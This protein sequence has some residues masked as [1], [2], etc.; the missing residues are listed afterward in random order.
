MRQWHINPKFLCRKHLL[1]EHVE[2]HMFIGALK[3]GKNL[4]GYIEKGLVE[5]NTLK[6]RHEEIV[7]ELKNRGY[8]H[9]SPLE[10]DPNLLYEAG[11]INKKSNFK[12][13]LRRCPECRSRFKQT[14]K[15]KS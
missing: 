10:I 5:I 3:K 13:L 7:E 6:E 12:E 11:K 1:G 9:N 15:G 2:H 4:K 14:I 8:N